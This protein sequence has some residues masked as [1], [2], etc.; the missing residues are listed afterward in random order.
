V[1]YSYTAT[2]SFTLAHARKLA[3][4][5]VADMHQCL[6]VYGRP[7]ETSIGAYQTELV[8]LLNG[9]YVSKYEFG[10]KTATE[11]RIVSWK[12]TV[13]SAG[14]LEGGRSGGLY[15]TAD[16]NGARMFNYLCHSDKW[17]GLTASE[18]AAVDAK[19]SIERVGCDPPS[20]GSGRWVRDR[21]YVSGGVA[22]ER[23]EFRPW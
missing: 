13:T 17:F 20:D 2:E 10:F 1:T 12:C 22:L 3:A 7:E 14:D 8:V 21:Q 4:K 23:E 15:A 19:H 6:R 16:V 18:Q 5:V 11:K 9:R